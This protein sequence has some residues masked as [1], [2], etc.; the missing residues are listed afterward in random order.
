M[1]AFISFG[2]N[3]GERS[4]NINNAIAHL[5][6]IPGVTIS[7]ISSIIETDPI[8]GPA[9]PKYLNGVVKIKTSLSPRTLFKRL[10]K[11]EVELGRIR[12]VKNGPRI[13]D[14]DILLYGRETIEEPDLK[15]P[16][17]RMFERAFV[18]QPLLEIEPIIIKQWLSQKISTKH[19]KL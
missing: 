14:L 17:P 6:K 11:I 16:H 2:S 10:Q 5:K 15:I 18:M 8:G 19:E 13:I 3:L 1:D 4:E 12:S 7:K 9:Q